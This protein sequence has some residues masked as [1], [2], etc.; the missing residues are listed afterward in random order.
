MPR[1]PCR[2]IIAPAQGPTAADATMAAE[3]AAKTMTGLVPRSRAIGVA[4]T[5]GR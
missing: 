5:A 2:S 3:K 4:S 1:P